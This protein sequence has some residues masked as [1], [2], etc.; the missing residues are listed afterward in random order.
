MNGRLSTRLERL[1]ADAGAA[2]GAV[3]LIIQQPYE[4]LEQAMARWHAE[5]PG[6]VLS[7]G[8]ILVVQLVG[9]A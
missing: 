5:H 6:E 4:S 7:P 1:E 2:E 8:V 3:S 9:S